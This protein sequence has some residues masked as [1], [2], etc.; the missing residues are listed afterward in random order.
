MYI[1]ICTF[2]SNTINLGTI[3]ASCRVPPG[4]RG[5]GGVDQFIKFI[6]VFSYIYI[7][8]IYT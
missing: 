3:S 5:T 7:Y 1:Y 6:C 8:V 2:I 4:R